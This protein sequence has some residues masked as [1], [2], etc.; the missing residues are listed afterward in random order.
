MQ[1][2]TKFSYHVV[3]DSSRPHGLQYT[4]LPCP[5]PS[6]GVC[7][8]SCPLYCWSH[9]TILFSV[10]LFY[11]YLQSFWASGSFPISRL[12]SSDGQSIGAS[13]SVLPMSIR[14]WFPLRLTDL[15]SL[16]SRGFSRVFSSTT[17]WKHQFFCT[18]LSFFLLFSSY[19]SL[20]SKSHIHALTVNGYQRELS[21]MVKVKHML[22]P[23]MLNCLWN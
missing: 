23:R 22:S 9:L 20:W 5:L 18:Q 16:L 1:H 19:L 2:V 17:V 12:I 3:S 10:T 15:I 11:F 13:A 6:L 21:G 7:P 4:R 8:S 14:S